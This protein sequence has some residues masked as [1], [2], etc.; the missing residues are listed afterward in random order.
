ME[1]AIERVRQKVKKRPERDTREI[2]LQRKKKCEGYPKRDW[3]YINEK[4][5]RVKKREI[6]REKRERKRKGARKER[7]KERKKERMKE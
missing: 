2:D 1:K 7:K 4:E 5:K 3:R 6:E